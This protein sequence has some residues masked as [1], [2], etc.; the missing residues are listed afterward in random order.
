M[1][2]TYGLGAKLWLLG[3]VAQDGRT[4][5]KVSDAD[6]I[7]GFIPEGTRLADTRPQSSV[8]VMI[9]RGKRNMLVGGLWCGG[10]LAVTLYTHAT[11]SG[12]GTYVVAW[13]AIIFGGWQAIKGLAQYMGSGES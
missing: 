3:A 10:G 12:G 13:G 7:K 6:G 4:W 11:A 2:V 5:L 8:Q 1:L 9:A